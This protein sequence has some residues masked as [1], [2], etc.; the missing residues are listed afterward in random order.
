MYWEDEKRIQNLSHKI[1]MER[2]RDVGVD[3]G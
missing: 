2:M 1:L 3:G